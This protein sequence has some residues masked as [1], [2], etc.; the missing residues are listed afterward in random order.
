MNMPKTVLWSAMIIAVAVGSGAQ[1]QPAPTTI[2]PG[3][4]VCRSATS[5]ELEIGT[6]P[7]IRYQIDPSALAAA[8]KER[9][10]KQ[11]TPKAAACVASATGT[12][13]KGGGMKLATIKFY[14]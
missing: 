14:N 9:L 5:C 8:D 11:C 13:T 6:P 4:V 7:S 2:G 3:R 1:G 10:T 12:E